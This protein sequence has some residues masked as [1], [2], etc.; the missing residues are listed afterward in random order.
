MYTY[1]QALDITYYTF[2]EHNRVFY[3][4]YECN[5]DS[6]IIFVRLRNYKVVHTIYT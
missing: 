4:H 5:I 3:N 6:T 1:I 2:T